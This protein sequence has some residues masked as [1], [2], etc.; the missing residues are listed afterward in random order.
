M[1]HDTLNKLKSF[2]KGYCL[3]LQQLRGNVYIDPE[4]DQG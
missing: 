2:N 4:G 3:L 1:Y